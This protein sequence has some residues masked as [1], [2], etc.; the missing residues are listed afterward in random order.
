[1]RRAFCGVE[2]E[3]A[4]ERAS[5]SVISADVQK[6]DLGGWDGRL[7]GGQ[8]KI[9]LLEGKKTRGVFERLMLKCTKK[10]KIFY[11]SKKAFKNYRKRQGNVSEMEPLKRCLTALNCFN[12]DMSCHSHK[13]MCC[14]DPWF[15]QETTFFWKN[16]FVAIT[17]V[18]W[19]KKRKVLKKTAWR[20]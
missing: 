12:P 19:K 4:S 8:C 3:R 14:H 20:I 1:M 7:E 15:D 13:E 10:K 6:S 9:R 17:E 18:F 2:G 11:Y 5:V 16:H